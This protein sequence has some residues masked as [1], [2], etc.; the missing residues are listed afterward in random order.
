MPFVADRPPVIWLGIGLFFGILIGLVVL[1]AA[2]DE[3]ASESDAN[4]RDRPQPP[5]RRAPGDEDHDPRQE[6]N[7]AR[8][9]V[10]KVHF[11]KKFVAALT[12]RPDNRFPAPAYEPLLKSGESI[13]CADCHDPDTLD[14]D[15][16]L[17]RDPGAA[18]VEPLRRK[19]RRFM[20]PL[21]E[22]WVERLNERHGAKLN[23]P[24]TCTDCHAWDPR[25]GEG[26]RVLPALMANFVR[27]LK[28]PPAIRDPASNWRPLLKDPETA[29]ML[30]ADCHGSSGEA[31][32]GDLDRIVDPAAAARYAGDKRFM[33]HLMERWATRLN[34][35][36]ADQ[37]V[38]AVV[39]IDCHDRDPRR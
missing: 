19:R 36:M 2:T 35:E 6:A 11:M 34:R 4:H 3:D 31:M 38:K 28:E 9:R 23:R 12:T 25:S 13:A 39:C 26:K 8:Q 1:V 32:E 7:R 24:V 15:A 37:L 29:S 21:M 14:L 16:M 30:C 10:A 5:P 18:A 17:K 22:A 27:A 20:I 33:T